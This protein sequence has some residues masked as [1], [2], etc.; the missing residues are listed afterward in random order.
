MGAR[1]FGLVEAFVA[2]IS[3][4]YYRPLMT[5]DDVLDELLTQ[6]GRQFDPA[7]VALLLDLI[8][9]K[10]L[11]SIDSEQIVSAKRRLLQCTKSQT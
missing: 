10:R 11:L 2:M 8:A 7:L 4:R 1:L 5:P 3:E 6:A 9:E